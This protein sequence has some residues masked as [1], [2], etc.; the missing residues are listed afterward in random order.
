MSTLICFAGAP[1]VGKT[2]SALA[3]KKHLEAHGKQVGY[4]GEYARD[5]I[6]LYGHPEHSAI[7]LHIMRQQKA[8]EESAF[9]GNDFA[10]TDTA[11][12]Y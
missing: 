1:G 4:S 11:V 10:V 9:Y 3:L 6:G 8:W 5:F 7:Q 2:T 12:W